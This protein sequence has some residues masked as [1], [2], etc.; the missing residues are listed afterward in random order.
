MMP[1]GTRAQTFTLEAVVAAILLVA[2]VAF[3]LG[4]VSVSTNTAGVAD[5][6]PRGQHGGL[7]AGVLDRTANGGE[8][9]SMLLYW[10]ESR[11][12]FYGANGDDG[13]YVSRTPDTAFGK[14]VD[15][16]FDEPGVQYAVTLYYPDGDGGR[17]ARPL[18]ASGT[19]GDD[20]AR[21]VET[22]TLYDQ[23]RLVDGNETV[24]EGTTLESV[25]P[26]FYAPD[27]GDDSTL[28]TVIRVEVVVWGT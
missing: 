8:L 15:R 7:A 19:P 20:A 25:E 1:R 5:A 14:A 18:I 6:E 22:V 27:A 16:L 17:V 23:T 28:Y 26:S 4:A 10:N 12:A 21:A 11:G 9:R 2:A 3:A 24:R 13:A